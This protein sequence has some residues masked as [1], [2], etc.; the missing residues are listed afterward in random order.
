MID[1]FWVTVLLLIAI[2][3]LAAAAWKQLKSRTFI[4]YVLSAVLCLQVILGVLAI[5]VTH[6]VNLLQMLG[7]LGFGRWTFALL[8]FS[9][10]IMAMLALIGLITTLYTAPLKET[11][12]GS[13]LLMAT[14]VAVQYL[15]S[16]FLV[17][18]QN[19]IPFLI[20]WEGM[21]LCAYAY[22]LTD[23]R[24]RKARHAA[25]VTLA[26]SELG[27]LAL[28]LAFIMSASPTGSMDLLSMS[29]VIMHFP[30]GYQVTIFLLGFFG[31][32]V[33]SGVLP[34]QMWMPR[35]YEVTP[36]HLSAILA[37]GLLN[38]G[39][40]GII[41]F[42]SLFTTLPTGLGVF[43]I[44]LGSLAVFLGAMYALIET[45]IRMILAFSSI[46]N[47]GFMVI[48]LGLAIA[49]AA[50]G[51]RY[52]ASVALVAMMF[53]LT[54][55]ALAKA[56]AFLTTGGIFRRFGILSIDQLG[57][58]WSQ[59][60]G[61]ASAFL[62]A[63][64]SLA[65]VAPFSGF[66][67]EWL[68]LQSMLQV[69]RSL[70]SLEQFLVVLAGVLT[71]LGAA[72][73]MSAFLRL[74]AHTMTGKLRQ[75]LV[76]TLPATSLGASGVLGV[77]LL[78]I[79]LAWIGLYPTGILPAI[80]TI[81]T[82]LPPHIMVVNAMIPN[83]FP[84][85]L[86]NQTLVQL[87]GGWLS[88]LP[89]L[90]FVIQPAAGVSSIA[91]TYIL[92]WFFCFMALALLIKKISRLHRH[93]FATRSVVAWNGGKPISSSSYQYTASAFSNPHRMFF[94]TLLRFKVRRTVLVGTPDAPT[95]IHVET[96]VRPWLQSAIY[97]K[98]IRTLRSWAKLFLRVQ[99]GY[100]WGYVFTALVAVLLMLWSTKII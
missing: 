51:N 64:L 30:I 22:I 45:R 75:P 99:H 67:A 29:Q 91:P 48:S 15:F 86:G 78:S 80:G 26:V 85:P 49:F 33:K 8:P 76:L 97:A 13:G 95:V 60:K 65:A 58:L 40:F 46:E 53:Q 12:P 25:F 17:V 72:M 69:Y 56:L 74:F 66:T 77:T 98:S 92:W 2:P 5:R 34:V 94:A 4:W 1:L 55:H 27:F 23:H 24:A 18:S 7:L 31:F 28:I 100:L 90:G 59:A 87:G 43:L 79:V 70:S 73:S 10:W 96:S 44:I 68:T 82:S 38:L 20:A 84:N 35:A 9:G 52:F 47:V 14:I 50:S 93:G 39:L 41:T 83:V 88:F 62:L 32:G 3:L 19:A 71:A 6:P 36:N 81:V 61:L 37:G 89:A 54:S 42:Y 63:C 21:S 11:V 16:M 57:G